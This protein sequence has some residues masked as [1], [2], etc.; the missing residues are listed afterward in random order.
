LL[1]RAGA[2]TG[3]DEG[4]AAITNTRITFRGPGHSSE[5]VFAKLTGVD[6]AT[7]SSWTALC[8]AN[9][10]STSGLGYPSAAAEEVRFQIRLAV[11][12]FH[13]AREDLVGQLRSDLEAEGAVPWSSEG[14]PVRQ[15]A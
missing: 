11:A 5:W 1:P 3:I 6:H 9:R 7:D 13:N 8:V 14:A 15:R 10:Q 12:E 4:R 2:P